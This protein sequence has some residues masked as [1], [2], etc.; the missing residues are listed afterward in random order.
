VFSRARLLYGSLVIEDIQDY[1]VLNRLMTNCTVAQDYGDYAGAIYEGM[2]D[3]KTRALIQSTSLTT[4]GDGAVGSNA[5][6]NNLS[7]NDYYGQFFQV[8]L[9]LGLFTQ[10]KLLPLKWMASSLR[11]ELYI[12]PA[13]QAIII[14]NPSVAYPIG[15][16]ESAVQG[17]DPPYNASAH[18]TTSADT[19]R[20]NILFG[21]TGTGGGFATTTA[22]DAILQYG[23]YAG[24]DNF[25]DDGGVPFTGIPE[26]VEGMFKAT[27]ELWDV[28]LVIELNDFDDSYDSAF[29][30]GLNSSGVPIHFMSWHSFP[31][32]IIGSNA[33]YPIQERAKSIKAAFACITSNALNTDNQL[34]YLYDSFAF[35]RLSLKEYIWRVGGKYYPSQGV[36]T[37][38]IGGEAFVELQKALNML[39]NYEAGC[40]IHP[41]LYG[42]VNGGETYS[43]QR[44]DGTDESF[45]LDQQD[46]TFQPQDGFI[47]SG[48]AVQVP[49]PQSAADLWQWRGSIDHPN[50]KHYPW[51]NILAGNRPLALA[52]GACSAFCIGSSFETT[53]GLEISGLNGEEQNEILMKLTHGRTITPGINTLFVF[54]YYDSM[55]V[56]RPN[57][58]VDLIF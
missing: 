31:F 22:E 13:Y 52:G 7:T 49:T 29:L 20:N 34:A 50:G 6:P 43:D 16:S 48:G 42:S 36:S 41:L 46:V 51:I 30:Q 57:N 28:A 55:I 54:V 58:V 12:A 2:G 1:N 25:R 4:L 53:N 38:G 8:N 33:Q 23:V 17:N 32:G 24:I 10:R 26:I 18:L 35:T 14:G 45:F 11:L 5:P 19:F 9:M 21:N 27:Y 40:Q 56:I 3:E 15:S 37:A 44:L 47:S 39:G